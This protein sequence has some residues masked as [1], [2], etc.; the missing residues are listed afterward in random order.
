MILAP[1][2]EIPDSALADLAG[3]MFATTTA[4][5]VLFPSPLVSAAYEPTSAPD[6]GV[7][8]RNRGRTLDSPGTKATKARR[9]AEAAVK[10]GKAW[11]EA[12]RTKAAWSLK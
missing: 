4:T 2:V 9:K 7:P 12:T 6:P 8:K 10:A 3:E 5:A 1:T 11:A